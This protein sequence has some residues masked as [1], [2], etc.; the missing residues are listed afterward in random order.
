MAY[1]KKN[2]LMQILEVQQTFKEHYKKGMMISYVYDEFIYPKYKISRATFFKY[3]K[4]N[5]AGELRDHLE[6]LKGKKKWDQLELPG[7]APA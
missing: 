5:A 7:F 6:D 1:T 3:M 4:R 2:K